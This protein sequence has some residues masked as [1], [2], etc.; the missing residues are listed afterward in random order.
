MSTNDDAPQDFSKHKGVWAY[1]EQTDGD[2]AN[3]GWELIGKGREL[4]NTLGSTLSGVIMGHNMKS[5]IKEVANFEVDSLYIIDNPLLKNYRT[6]PYSNG[7]VKLVR[8]YK[9]EIV[10]Y[11]ATNQGRDLA[12][13]VA[14]IIETG[15]TADCTGLEI[16]PETKLLKQIRPA[17]GGNI[18]AV[19]LTKNHRP[20]MATVRPRVFKMPDKRSEEKLPTKKTETVYENLELNED[21]IPVKVL[22]TEQNKL[23]VSLEEADII[24]SGGRGL[25]S[26]KNFYII[27]EMAKALGGEVGASRSA[28]DAG[29]ISSDHQVGQTGQT[30][31]PRLYVAVGISGAIQHLV[32][33]SNSDVIVAVN[34]DSSAPIFKVAHIGI[35]GDLF[36]IVPRLTEQ[37]KEKLTEK[38]PPC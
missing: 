13:A 8:K 27:E 17:F 11:G 14:T 35:I 2:A 3:V 23:G 26:A 34:K 37:L 20:Q 7:M 21:D 6:K 36:K 16:D 33:M 9:P 38:S 28:V 24:V 30:V 32:G 5:I 10:L 12:S 1:I 15:L 22:K 19:I 31:R 29:W 4:A 25:G 18:M